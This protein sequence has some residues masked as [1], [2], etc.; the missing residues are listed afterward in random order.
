MRCGPSA[1]FFLPAIGYW[2]LAT[3]SLA[4]IPADQLLHSLRPAAYVNDYAGILQPDQRQALED[5]CQLLQRQTGAE[6]A[7]VI[8]RSLQGGQIDDFANKLFRQ[9]GIGQ[10]GKDNGLLFLIALDDRKAR[11]EVGRGL[12]PILPDAI[13]GRILDQQLFPAFKQQRY[14]DGLQAAVARIAEIVEK[15]EPVQVAGLGAANQALPILPIVLFLAMFVGFGGFVLG[16]SAKSKSGGMILFGLLF[17]AIPLLIG[18]QMAFPWAPIIHVPLG[19]IAAWLG[20]RSPTNFS[21]WNRPYGG[22]SSPWMW[23]D[24]SGGGFSSGW[25]GFGGGGGSD[26]GGGGGGGFGGFG[27]GDSGGGGAS[28]GW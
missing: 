21:D 3:I 13:E 2:L 28:G 18:C 19:L 23:N 6:L 11:I 16:M 25:G 26:W 5:R 4:Q 22:G 9:W 17:C 7:V 20:Y 27:G 10:K 24:W 1:R 15:N 12:E 14:F 8:V